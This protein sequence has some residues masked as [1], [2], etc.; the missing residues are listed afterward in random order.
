MVYFRKIRWKNL[1]STGN[2]W[3]EIQLD[4][5]PNTLIIGLNGSGKSTFLDALIFAL[6]G[7][8]FRNINKPNLVNSIN[9]RDLMVELEFRIGVKE[10]LIRRGLKPGI[11]EIFD[12]GV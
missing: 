5:S 12:G 3:T 2:S 6:F 4:K 10:Y 8:A 1:L 11:F 9:D 7:V